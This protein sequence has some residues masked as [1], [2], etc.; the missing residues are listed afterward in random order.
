MR[1]PKPQDFHVFRHHFPLT[2]AL[3]LGEG[4]NRFLP[5]KA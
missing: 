1:Y 4:E 3:S 2:A 5:L